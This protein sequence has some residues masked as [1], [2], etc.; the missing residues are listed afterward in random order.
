MK[1]GSGI[2][3]ISAFGLAYEIGMNQGIITSVFGMTPFV[4]SL[5]FYG[6]FREKLKFSQLVGMVF[7]VACVVMIALGSGKYHSRVVKPGEEESTIF[8]IP[9]SLLCVILACICPIFFAL[10]GLI[11]R[12]A[13]LEFNVDPTEFTQV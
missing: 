8:Y 4:A 1:L 11:I 7:M 2:I 12:I 6:L 5:I 10:A 13:K 9:K 3:V